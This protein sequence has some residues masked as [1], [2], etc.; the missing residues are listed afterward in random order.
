M[1]TIISA[2]IYFV[3]QGKELAYQLEYSDGT[4]VRAV[5]TTY[6]Y[7]RKEWKDGDEW[8]LSGKPY[9]VKKDSNRAVELIKAEVRKYIDGE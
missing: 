5:E 8:K 1:I 4:K 6:G 3:V 7:I 2:Q 9:I